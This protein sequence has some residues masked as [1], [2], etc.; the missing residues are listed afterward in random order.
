[1]SQM[2]Q[3]INS[4]ISTPELE[5]R[6]ALVRKAMEEWQIDVLLMQNNN[7]HMGGYTKYFTDV[8]ASSGY[9][10]TVVF[11][12]D[13][14]MTVVKQGPFGLE[15]E[16]DPS[17]SDGFNRGVGRIMTTPSYESAPYT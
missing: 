16:I 12:A 9:P 8:P 17:G 15:K 3:R 10:D 4:P 6:W 7:D 14:L 1:M 5:R 11:P 2:S 13:G